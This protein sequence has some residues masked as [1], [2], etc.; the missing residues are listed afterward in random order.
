[1][2]VE[3]LN[4]FDGKITLQIGDRQNRDLDG[5]QMLP[6]TIPPGETEINLPIYLPETMHINVQSQSQLY[7]QAFATYRDHNG[8]EQSVLVL[9]EKRNMLR[10]LPP[11]VK[12]KT[13]SK[14]VSAKP[15]GQATCRLRLQRTSNFPGPMNLR[16][17]EQSL[18]AGFQVEAANIAASKRD[19]NV[20]LKL[21]ADAKPGTTHRLKFEARGRMPNGTLVI[22]G[23]TVTVR[24]E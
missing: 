22:T 21:P 24:V 23:T 6:V 2:L 7:S 12:L 15:G 1:M 8:I 10:T 19:C 9:S 16:L 14:T 5:I 17:L 11:V 18:N 4:G 20:S 3:R 13:V